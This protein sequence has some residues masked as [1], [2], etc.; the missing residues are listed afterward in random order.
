M[1]RTYLLLVLVAA[2]GGPL[3]QKQLHGEV[4]SLHSLAAESRLLFERDVTQHYFDEHRQMLA[5]NI[6]DASK[7]LARGVDDPALEPDQKTAYVLAR[8]LEPIVRA[9]KDPRAIQ[10]IEQLLAG[11]DT[12]LAP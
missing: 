7:Q 6:R 1:R 9:G 12:R 2:C 11:I 3:D 8:A 4:E 10:P 5:D